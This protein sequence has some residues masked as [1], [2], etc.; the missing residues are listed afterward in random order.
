M[1]INKQ[2]TPMNFAKSL[3]ALLVAGGI[4]LSAGTPGAAAA[5]TKADA[6]DIKKIENYL[7]A[8]KTMRADFV[9]IA[10]NGEKVEGRMYIEKPNKIRMEYDKPSD[11]LIVGNGDYVV[12]Y[13]KELEQITN[14]DY[15]EIPAAAILAD[16][17]KIDGKEIEVVDYYEDP[18]VTRIGLKY[19][20]S[21]DL[22]PFTLVF[23]NSPFE[24]RQWKV[25]TPQAM[26]VSLS[27]YNAVTDGKLD[28]SLFEF[29]KNEETQDSRRDRFKRK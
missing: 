23:A 15:D 27:L 19:A 12:Y 10:S 18:G 13:D 9:Q 21:G 28:E 17:V 7:N 5:E 22:G 6:A 4:S 16:T 2:D 1:E 24:L 25:I 14:I 8:I 26:E 20:H 3:P 11:V 29:R